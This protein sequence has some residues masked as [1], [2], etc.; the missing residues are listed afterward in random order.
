MGK[1]FF[2]KLFTVFFTLGYLINI[3]VEGAVFEKKQQEQVEVQSDENIESVGD[4]YREID[5]GS[6]EGLA[7]ILDMPDSVVEHKL[8]EYSFYGESEKLRKKKRRSRRQDKEPPRKK[9]SKSKDKDNVQN[10]IDVASLVKEISTAVKSDLDAER[11]AKEERERADK[12]AADKV[13]V[14][15]TTA[16]E[17]IVKDLREELVA[18][19]KDLSEQIGLL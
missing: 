2:I 9:Q 7:R 14:I 4:D 3:P 17:R 13:E 1:I 12:E 10:P 15:A 8:D 6:T 18:K 16:A 11:K 19:D 5:R